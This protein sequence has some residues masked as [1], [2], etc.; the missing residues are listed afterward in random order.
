VTAAGA[1]RDRGFELGDAVA[2]HQA[3][4]VEHTCHRGRFL[5]A[6]LNA[7]ERNQV[8]LS[9]SRSF[10]L[11]AATALERDDA[12]AQTAALVRY[13]AFGFAIQTRRPHDAIP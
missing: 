3:T 8:T 12:L 6:E 2:L 13:R 1:L 10:A 7:S 9:I 5:G 4:T 11:R